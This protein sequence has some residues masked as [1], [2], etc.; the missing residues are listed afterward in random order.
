[1]NAAQQ[2]RS[3]LGIEAGNYEKQQRNY[4]FTKKG[5]GRVHKLPRRAIIAQLSND[6]GA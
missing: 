2:I 3:A 1:M 5:P 4:S 6:A